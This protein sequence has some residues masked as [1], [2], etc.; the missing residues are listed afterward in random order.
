LRYALVLTAVLLSLV[1]AWGAC[2]DRGGPGYRA[3]NGRCVG[4]A[5]IGKTCGN[6][7]TLRCSA[8][9]ADAGA[10]E[11]AE[12]GEKAIQAKRGGRTLLPSLPAPTIETD[13]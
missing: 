3:A 1:P 2:G 10:H 13:R 5:D 12:H 9:N 8:E 7:P 11:A 4:W 6:P